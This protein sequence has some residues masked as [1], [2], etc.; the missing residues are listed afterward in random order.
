MKG[1]HYVD[2]WLLS[3]TKALPESSQ[4]TNKDEYETIEQRKFF[5][6]GLLLKYMTRLSV[7]FV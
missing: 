1:K 7:Q 4:S 2:K 6:M 3:S 5:K